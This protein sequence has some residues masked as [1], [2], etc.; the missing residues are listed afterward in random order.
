MNKESL[1]RA[2]PV[3]IYSVLYFSL[4]GFA[5]YSLFFTSSVVLQ[6]VSIGLYLG[7]LVFQ[8]IS[9]QKHK[10]NMTEEELVSWRKR[11]R[12]K[13]GLLAI[14]LVKYFIKLGTGEIQNRNYYEKSE[15]W[16][17]M[18]YISNK[19][20]SNVTVSYLTEYGNDIESYSIE[21]EQSVR[22]SLNLYETRSSLPIP[23]KGGVLL[24]FNDS[25]SIS[26]TIK[27][28]GGFMP[29]NHNLLDWSK[30]EKEQQDESKIVIYTYTITQQD[31]IEAYNLH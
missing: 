8:T 18:M 7:L 30:W 25:I 13:W 16:M 15:N 4:F 9:N 24:T 5:F 21:P 10:K 22:I 14:F 6:I 11:Q 23:N 1:K 26:H 17:K 2:M 12:M 20:E 31:Y 28:N 3:I 27:E 29:P 19:S